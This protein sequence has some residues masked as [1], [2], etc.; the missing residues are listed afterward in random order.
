MRA[1]CPRD[2]ERPFGV[3]ISRTT[4]SHSEVLMSFDQETRMKDRMS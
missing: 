1:Y 4:P 3:S 2:V